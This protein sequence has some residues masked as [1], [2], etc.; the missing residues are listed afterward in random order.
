MSQAD[1]VLRLL[2]SHHGRWFSH[3]AIARRMNIRPQAVFAIC[4]RLAEEGKVRRER[5][6]HQWWICY[7]EPHGP[8]PEVLSPPPISFDWIDD[9]RLRNV[10]R[11]DW[12]ETNR[13]FKT[14]AWKASVILGG[15]CLEGVLV[16]AVGRHEAEVRRWLPEDLKGYAISALPLRQLTRL[17]ERLGLLNP[18][19]ADFLVKSR[20]IVHPGNSAADPVPI[21]D[22]EARAGLALL[23][24][25]IRRAASVYLQNN[26]QAPR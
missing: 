7:G 6:G 16:A 4:R 26:S 15:A 8:I 19:S 10:V 13:C 24:A 9:Q 17:A 3:Q 12:D 22:G 25:C 21:N 5:K 18:R 23:D 11:S 2:A 14:G 1:S 20:N